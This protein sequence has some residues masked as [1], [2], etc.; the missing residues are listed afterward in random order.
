MS[1]GTLP[2]FSPSQIRTV[3]DSCI[4]HDQIVRVQATVCALETAKIEIQP[5][6]LLN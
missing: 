2:C 6:R 1:K 4:R 5:S 3:N